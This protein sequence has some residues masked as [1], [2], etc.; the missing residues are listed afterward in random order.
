MPPSLLE[1]IGFEKEEIDQGMVIYAPKGCPECKGSGY[2]GRVGLYELMEVG[3]L[4]KKT[5]VVAGII[6]WV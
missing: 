4:I 1:N 2:L 3:P 5:M 6:L